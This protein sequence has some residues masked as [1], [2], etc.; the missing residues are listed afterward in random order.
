[1]KNIHETPR[2][3]WRIEYSVQRKQIVE[4]SEVRWIMLS[5]RCFCEVS[6]SLLMVRWGPHMCAR[7]VYIPMIKLSSACIMIVYLLTFPVG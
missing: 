6:L 3:R 7:A 4:T 5:Y 2:Q 1:M